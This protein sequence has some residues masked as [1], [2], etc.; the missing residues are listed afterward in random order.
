MTAWY[1]AGTVTATN[2]ST[3]VTGALTAWLANA[4]VGDLWCPDADGR[5]YEITAVGSNTSIT[6]Y[7]AYAGSTGSGKAYG[8]A[9]VSTSWNSV[10]EIGVSLAEILAAQPDILAGSGVPSDSIGQDGDVYFRQDIAEYYTKGAGTWI[11]VT[12]LIGPQGP[13]GPSYQATSTSSVAIGAGAKT[14]T[15]Q[16]GRGYSAGQWLRV[17]NSSSNYMEGTVTSYSSTTLII[18]V[19]TGRAI[20]S[21][22]FTSWNV[23]IAGDVGPANSLAIGSVTTGAAGSSASATITGTA[24]SQ[25]LDLVIPRGNT[26][27][28][29]AAGPQ[30]ATGSAATITVGTVD[31]V[32]PD[33]PATVTN[34]GTSGAA[35]LDF[36]IPK[37]DPGTPINHRGDYNGATTYALNDAVRVLGSTWV[38]INATPGSGNAPPTLPTESN[39]YWQLMAQA[40]SNGTGAVDLVNGQSGVVVLGGSDIEANYAPVNYSPA[41]Q[42]ITDHFAAL[43]TV[44]APGSLPLG[45]LASASTCDIGAVAALEVFITG[46]TTITSFGTVANKWRIV[47]FQSTLTLTHNASTLILPGAANITTTAGDIAIFESDASGNW[48]CASYNFSDGRAVSLRTILKANRNYYVRTDGS[49][50]NT[51]LA[52]NS[53]GAFLTLQKA[54][55]IV[56]ALDIGIYDVTIN[57]GSGTFARTGNNTVK[58]PIGYGNVTVSGAG[59]ASSTISVTSGSCFFSDT[60]NFRFTVSNLAVTTTTSGSGI[61]MFGT[62]LFNFSNVDFQACA[63]PHLRAESGGSLVATGNYTVSGGSNYHML[64]GLRST[65]STAVRTVTLT[66]TPAFSTAFMGAIRG[67]YIVCNGMTFSGSAT[68][69]RYLATSAAVI[70]TNAGGASYL[71]GNSAGSTSTSGLY[72]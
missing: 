30:G 48:R 25:T 47:R 34:S 12:A 35:V 63:G 43:D 58:P 13:A 6:I 70:D 53:G 50:G 28:T 61:Y 23:N 39:S 11:L 22:T 15:V 67:A 65:G 72:I 55:D 40:G 24:P 17:S 68:G 3:A 1:R 21:G 20:G 7:P 36:E 10:S 29:G 26:G 62:G 33:D 52:N 32:D 27:A 38:Y 56:G 37:G 44:N 8:I 14:F 57:I 18:N 41:G 71:P 42:A 49:D 2:G 64:C 45:T 4:K 31:T 69:A 54:F 60:P 9:R 5:G 51:G 16:S 66:G 59:M 19:P 46:T